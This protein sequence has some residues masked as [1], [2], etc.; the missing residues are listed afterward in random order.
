V[1]PERLAVL[2]RILGE[3]GTVYRSQLSDQQRAHLPVL[4]GSGHV[5][6]DGRRVK[7]TAA[8]R[9]VAQQAREHG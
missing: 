9:T 1:T 4:L 7:L 6:D 5:T 3:G 8:R 2:V